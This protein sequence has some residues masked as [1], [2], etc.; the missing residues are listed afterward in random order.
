MGSEPG[1]GGES[2][3]FFVDYTSRTAQRTGSLP[4]KRPSGE[5]FPMSGLRNPP[6]QRR[7]RD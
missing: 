4:K 3:T 7:G 5:R 6:E 1:T 2:Q